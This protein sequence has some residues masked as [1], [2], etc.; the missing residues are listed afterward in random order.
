MS[1]GSR[2]PKRR[3]AGDDGRSEDGGASAPPQ[4]EGETAVI[5]G[6]APVVTMRG[7]QTELISYTKGRGRMT[8]TLK[9][10]EPCHNAEEVIAKRG[11]DPE[12]DLENPTGFGILRTRRRIP[13]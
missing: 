2:F 9:G 3:S 8:C 6:S 4:M 1:F 10:Y 11:Y 12:A 7:Y 5:C 13:L